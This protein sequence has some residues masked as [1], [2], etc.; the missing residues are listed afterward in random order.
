[1]SHLIV[2][3]AGP[4]QTWAGYRVAYK[5]VPTHPI[6]TKSG[7][8]GLLGACLGSR[9]LDMLMTRFVLRVRVDRT[10][11]IQADLQVATGPKPH[12]AAR[13]ERARTLAAGVKARPLT[14]LTGTADPGFSERDYIPA[15]EFICELAGDPV[16]VERWAAATR[17][18]VFMPYLG[19]RAN[20]PTFPFVLGTYAGTGDILKTLPTVARTRTAEA[21]SRLRV[22]T[23]TGSYHQHTTEMTTLDVPVVPTREEQLQWATQHLN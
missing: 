11:P 10:N 20:P 23:V 14:Q 15:A 19:R 17:D 13:F 6:P 18:P 21:S 1:M 16:D 9:D 22:Y 4:V 7:V 2:R 3:L 8:A 5:R 12:E